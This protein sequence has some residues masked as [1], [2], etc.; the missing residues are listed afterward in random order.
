MI[1]RI[2]IQI[3]GVAPDF[4]DLKLEDVMSTFD[5]FKGKQ[6]GV[7]NSLT[8]TFKKSK[9]TLRIEGSLHKSVKENNYEPFAYSEAVAVLQ[10]IASFLEIPLSAFRINSIEIGVNIS[11][12]ELPM[13]Y[14][15]TISEYKGNKLYP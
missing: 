8:Y 13:R 4:V 12:N 11:V 6:T 3:N 10:E 1:D 7:R 9:A 14:I 5:E 15:E 2:V